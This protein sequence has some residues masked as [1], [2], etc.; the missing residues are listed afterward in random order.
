MQISC[1]YG[2]RTGAL[3][4]MSCDPGKVRVGKPDVK[5]EEASGG[6]TGN[7]NWGSQRPFCNG[8]QK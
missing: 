8:E 2:Y 4:S 5:C 3:C 7:W 6:L 1:P